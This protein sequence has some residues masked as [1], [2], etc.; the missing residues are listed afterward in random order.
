MRR[1]VFPLLVIL[2]LLTVIL[3]R[4][5]IF[6]G[7]AGVLLTALFLSTLKAGLIVHGFMEVSHYPPADRLYALA[8]L[9]WILILLVLMFSDY[10]SRGDWRI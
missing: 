10:A 6:Q 3:S 4:F 2:V 7:S 8:G 1:W 9:G 5:P